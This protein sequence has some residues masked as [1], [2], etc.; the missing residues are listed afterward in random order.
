M[1]KP[2]TTPTLSY[3]KPK[4]NALTITRFHNQNQPPTKQNKNL[5]VKNSNP[6][7][8]CNK[9]CNNLRPATD[10]CQKSYL[11]IISNS[12][13]STYT[14][15]GLKT[16]IETTYPK[17]ANDPNDKF[18]IIF[19]SM[20]S[21][22]SYIASPSYPTSKQIGFTLSLSSTSSGV[23][24]VLRTNSTFHSNLEDSRPGIST[25]PDT[26]FLFNHFAN[27]PGESCKLKPGAPDGEMKF[28]RG[29][30]L[31]AETKRHNTYTVTRPVSTGNKP[32]IKPITFSHKRTTLRIS[33]PFTSPCVCVCFF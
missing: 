9:V 25:T 29:E 19:P 4:P 20:S 8:V 15:S 16:Y 12:S 5:Q 23:S 27:G 22:N 1:L 30:T 11:A 21:L 26:K 28:W 13:E 7:L 33:K 14:A 24:T 6:F 32:S 17:T 18:T 10:F 2:V 3:P 31:G